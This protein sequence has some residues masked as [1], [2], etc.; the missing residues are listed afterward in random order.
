MA[1]GQPQ[2]GEGEFRERLGSPK[3]WEIQSTKESI[4]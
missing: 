1:D 2:D 3:H 4:S